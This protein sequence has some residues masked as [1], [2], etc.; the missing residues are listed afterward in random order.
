MP[1]YSMDNTHFA[2]DYIIKWFDINQ[3]FFI[4]YKFSI[5]KND[6]IVKYKNRKPIPL[7]GFLFSKES[8]VL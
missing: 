5:Q 7:L 8:T 3:C 4:K 6:N 2:N 1:S